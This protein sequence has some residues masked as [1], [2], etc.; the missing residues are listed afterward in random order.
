VHIRADGGPDLGW[1]HVVRCGALADELARRGAEVR[2]WLLDS[3][4][5]VRASL[6]SRFEVRTLSREIGVAG[7]PPPE[8]RPG[9]WIVADSY[10][11]G[12]RDA[13]ALKS[14]G[15]RLL[16]IHDGPGGRFEADLV[17]NPNLGADPSRYRAG[18]VLAG[19]R[20]ALL[21]REFLR[22]PKRRR[23]PASARSILV[24]FGGSDPRGLGPRICRLLPGRDVTCVAGPSAAS[25]S[26]PDG[27]RVIR[28][29]G[30]ARM[31][32]LMESCDLAVVSASSV[33]WE[34]ARL[35]VPTAVVS[36]APNQ[37]PIRRALAKAGMARDLGRYDHV[38]VRALGDL[39]EDRAARRRLSD[40]AARRVDGRGAARTAEA[41][42]VG[43]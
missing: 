25:G 8:F 3:D 2:W 15:A 7:P 27:V 23:V 13:R 18:R 19:P 30:A 41:M 11:L 5:A 36:V 9:D 12:A 40:A 39:V 38:R 26:F 33:C 37:E 17:L 29:A 22:P 28:G 1:G 43:R 4:A 42:R 32:A 20:Y 6:A 35:G 16:W 14:S 21:R 24:N 10:A 34:L 31:R